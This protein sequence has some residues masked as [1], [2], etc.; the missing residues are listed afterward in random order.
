[1]NVRDLLSGIAFAEQFRGL[2]LWV[3]GDQAQQLAANIARGS[4]DRRSN[5]GA[6]SINHIA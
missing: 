2:K 4:E 5:H 1:M 3:R 6:R